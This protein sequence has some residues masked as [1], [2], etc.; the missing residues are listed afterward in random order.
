LTADEI[1]RRGRDRILDGWCQGADARDEQGREV[2]PW[3]ADARAWSILGAVAGAEAVAV[4]VVQLGRAVVA[5]GQAAETQ[6]LGRWNDVVE[7]T[8]EEVVA[9]F[10]R[11]LATITAPPAVRTLRA[12]E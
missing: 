9:L 11:A 2:P 3:S 12:V 10:D 1:L 5:L 8:Q 6:S 4:P 7:R